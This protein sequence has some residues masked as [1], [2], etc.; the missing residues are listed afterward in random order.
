[1]RAS[2][3]LY[4]MALAASD[5]ADRIQVKSPVDPG[6]FASPWRMCDCSDMMLV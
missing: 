1:M 3:T 6:A 4:A 5:K 2:R